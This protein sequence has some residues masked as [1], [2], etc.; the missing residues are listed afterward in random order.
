MSNIFVQE[1]K[2]NNNIT[3]KEEIKKYIKKFCKIYFSI[4]KYKQIVLFTYILSNDL[5]LKTIK[6][7]LLLILF[8]IIF[9]LMN[10]F[11]LII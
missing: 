9:L 6:G 11:S 2:Y 1:F 4:L 5:N 7:A 10:Y 3:K 8:A